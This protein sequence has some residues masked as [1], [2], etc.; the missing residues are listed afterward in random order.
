MVLDAPLLGGRRGKVRDF[1]PGEGWREY[2]RQLAVLR[3]LLA[4]L[5]VD[6][7]VTADEYER[8]HANGRVAAV[9]ACEGGDHLEGDPSH[10]EEAYADG[11]R[12]MQP[13]HVASNPLVEIGDDGRDVGLT[14]AGRDVV[15]EMNRLGM[16]IEL[17]HASFTT[18]RAAAELST[19]P[20]I[21]SHSLIR[22]EGARGFGMTHDHARVIADTGGVIGAFGGTPSRDIP[23]YVDNILYMTE[24]VGIDHVGLGSDMDGTGGR[25][26]WDSYAQVPAVV[27]GL[28]QR[29]M[30]EDDVARVIGGNSLRLLREV[31][32]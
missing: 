20:I 21:Q 11:V 14:A 25:S 17:G 15:R 2:K 6:Q 23:G 1:E 30:S 26:V 5:P 32:G 9:F 19:A 8:T 22:R 4:D 18:A 16:V 13:F 3:A 29:G 27:A 7:V 24:V 12:H 28:L 31:A 10:V